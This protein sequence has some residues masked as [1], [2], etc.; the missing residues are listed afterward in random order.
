MR[1]LVGKCQ[2]HTRCLSRS[3]SPPSEP[4]SQALLNWRH[5]GRVERRKYTGSDLD[6]GSTATTC[7]TL[8]K[9]LVLSNFVF[10]TVKREDP[11]HKVVVRIRNCHLVRYW[12]HGRWTLESH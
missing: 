10:L 4:L 9:S 5:Q 7:M 12:A 6:P 2:T 3:V 8:N 11:A 1:C